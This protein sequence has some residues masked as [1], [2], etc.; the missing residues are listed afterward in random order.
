MLVTKPSTIKNF[1]KTALLTEFDLVLG[2]D[3][4]DYDKFEA[5]KA[6]QSTKIDLDK[7][8]E[9]VKDLV[10]KREEYRKNK[11]Y[12]KADE[13]RKELKELG[14]EIKDGAGVVEVLRL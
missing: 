1:E 2:F 4:N 9:A 11:E 12:D 14:Y 13:T 10:K 3:L 5:S 6:K 8:P 7:L